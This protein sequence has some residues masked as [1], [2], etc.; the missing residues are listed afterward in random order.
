MSS[1]D[2]SRSGFTLIELLVVIVIVGIVSAMV[3]LSLGIVGDDRGLQ[4]EAQRISSLITLVT[5]EAVMQGRDFGLEFM[6]TGYRFVEYD[7]LLDQWHEVVNDDLMRRRQLDEGTEIE[8]ILE[9]RPVLLKEQAAEMDEED[10]DTRRSDLTE[11]YLPHVLILSSGDV[12]PF[13]IA[14]IRQSDRAAVSL[15]MNVTGEIEIKTDAETAL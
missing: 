15:A 3:L 4:R 2:R 12:T 7:P 13:N 5:D 8:L 9:D 10:E 11:D 1:A 6:Q 14:F